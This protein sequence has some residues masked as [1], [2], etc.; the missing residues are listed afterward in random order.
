MRVYVLHYSVAYDVDE[1]VGV[2]A[3]SAL[4]REGAVWHF[5]S[6]VPN[7]ADRFTFG[8]WKYEGSDVAYLLHKEWPGYYKG[9]EESDQW[10]NI[11]SYVV[12]EA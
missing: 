3:T 9:G 2:Y 8:E 1:V 5:E 10:Y 12:V 6:M 7:K 4:A 11:D